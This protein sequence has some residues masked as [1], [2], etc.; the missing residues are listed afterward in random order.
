MFVWLLTVKNILP[1]AIA[2]LIVA[3][4]SIDNFGFVMSFW[5]FL[6]LAMLLRLVWNSSILIHGLGHVLAI[7]SVDRQLSVLSISNILEQRSIATTLKS[8]LPFNPIFIPLLERQSSLWVAAGDVTPWRIRVK[9]IGGIIFNL[10]AI[11]IGLLFYPHSLQHLLVGDNTISNFISVF[12][13]SSNLLIIISSLSDITALVTGI[14]DSFYCGNFGFVG[15]RHPSD[16]R[17]LLPERVVEMFYQMGRETEIRGEQA[18][19]GLVLARNQNNQTVFVGK[20]VVN[21]KRENLTKSLEAAFAPVRKNAIFTGIKPIESSIIGAWHYRFGTSGS[22]P[23]VLETHWHEWMSAR[24]EGVW[25]FSEDKWT[26]QLKN[27]NHRITHNGDFDGWMLFGKSIE[28]DKLGLWLERVLHTPNAT[29]GDSP[30]IAGMMDLLITKGMW[31]ASVRLAYQLAIA[32]SIESAFAG[33]KPSRHAPNTAPSEEELNNW[34]EIFESTFVL[35]RKLL[36]APDSPSCNQ[37]LCRLESDILQALAQN[38]SMSKLSWSKRVAF[39]RTAIEVFFKNDL[40]FATKT[41]MSKAEGSFGLVTISTLEEEQIVL[42]AQG[43][44]ISIG[45]NWQ[46][47]YMVYASEPAAIDTILLGLPESYRLDLEQ[48]SGE[49]ALVSAKNITIYSLSEKCE[50]TPSELKNRWISMEDHPYLPLIKYP[51]TDT[52]DPIASDTLEI[53]VV[54]EEIKLSWQNPASLNRKSAD[55][56]VDL[57]CEKAKRFEQK[58]QQMLRAGL[59]EQL[60]QLPTVDLL[61]TGVENSLWLGERF[62]QDLNIIFPGLN[63]LTISSNEVLQYL[64]QDFSSLQLGQDS[65]VLAITQ[66]GQ[67]FPTVQAINTFDQLSRQG[68]IGELFLLT[69]ELGSFLGSPVI[70]PK[71]PGTGD[72]HNIFVNGSGRRT[73]EAATVAVAA[74]Q[75]TLTELLF[76]LAKQM[77]QTFPDSNPFGMTLAEES[78]VV[79]EKMKDDFLEINVVQI[80]GITPTGKVIKSSMKQ[81]LLKAGRKWALHITETPL[82][83][84]IHALYVL[85]TVGWAIPFGYTIPLAK[86]IFSLIIWIA[87][88]PPI[89]FS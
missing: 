8:L 18:G 41:F 48:K 30:K 12:F 36:G 35:Y 82:A 81:K 21:K 87:N 53:P 46:E 32:E 69:G 60:R 6:L 24:Y 1:E 28:Y 73:A 64:G 57:L 83:W 70:Q 7:A 74:A 89:L 9:A 51:Q 79:L 23:S 76:Y 15:L 40:Y 10:G 39:V 34:A 22:P 77:R 88:I 85:I 52:K 37:Y 27:I 66:S 68:I 86:T 44:P 20:K 58:Q 54:L 11:A 56:L 78:L 4:M 75:Q 50:L 45:F 16:R 49:I 59:T 19:G 2:A 72:R 47:G 42:S 80:M 5:L 61:I 26:Y 3:D 33:E 65:L 25:E 67:T 84:G 71:L 14:A 55:Y 17:Q 43:Q 38:S 13:I 63:I 62:A 31:Y 29:K